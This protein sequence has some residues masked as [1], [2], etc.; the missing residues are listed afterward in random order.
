MLALALFLL[1]RDDICLAMAVAV[2]TVGGVNI[3][4]IS[5]K[6]KK[7]KKKRKKKKKKK[8]KK[9]RKP[10]RIEY[11]DALSAGRENV[12]ATCPHLC[13]RTFPNT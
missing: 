11:M 5:G 13:A 9:K 8:K 2:F 1:I 7:K 12:A 4:A 10:P 3:V 6:K